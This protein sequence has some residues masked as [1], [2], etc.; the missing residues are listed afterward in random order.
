M[1]AHRMRRID[2]GLQRG[3]RAGYDRAAC[4]TGCADP[5][6]RGFGA[7][8]FDIGDVTQRAADGEDRMQMPRERR[9][10]QFDARPA[11]AP[12]SQSS[13]ARAAAITGLRAG[14]P[15]R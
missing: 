4:E 1:R 2:D 9:R 11:H 5:R 7:D 3:V 15:S 14:S 10:Q 6:L 12:R 8:H 13:C